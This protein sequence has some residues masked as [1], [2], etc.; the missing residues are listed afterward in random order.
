MRV[1]IGRQ[2]IDINFPG[3]QFKLF[4]GLAL[5]F[6]LAY[7]ALNSFY[8]VKQD[9][10]AVVT[11]FGKYSKTVM[12][13]LHFQVPIVDKFEKVQVTRQMKAEFGF[14]SRTSSR[15]QETSR[16]AEA[17]KAM[18]T[19]D[20]SSALVEWVIQYRISDP[21]AYLFNVRNPDDTLRDASESI[22]REVVGDR[23]VDEV[24]TIGRQDIESTCQQKLA[25]LVKA[26][27][28]GM[29]IDQVQLKNVDPPR[30]V[31]ESF[32]EVNEAQQEKK[33]LIN[34]A[35][36]EYNRAVPKA[37]GSAD[38]LISEAEG[39][40]TKRINEA[41]GD[42]AKFNALYLEYSKAPDVTRRRIY[43]ETMEKVMP[44]LGKKVI[45]DEGASGVLPLLPLDAIGK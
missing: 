10:Q 31:Q 21:V 22:M 28:L 15:Y 23:T 26:Y 20:L 13:G 8:T 39:Y 1:Q 27:E 3:S 33:K 16:F 44:R 30:E 34:V 38:K 43:L 41:E 5:I 37:R 18:V 14:S 19:G 35:N 6:I 17:E 4:A 7:V 9:E 25:E 24:I 45:M 12:P 42:A 2:V 40:A 11:R 29:I 36:G 32:N